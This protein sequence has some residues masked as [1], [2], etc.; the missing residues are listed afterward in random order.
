MS[1]TID[2]YLTHLSP[3]AYL[4]HQAFQDLCAKHGVTIRARPVDLG[5]VF[6]SNGGLPFAKR[7][8][9]RLD[10]RMIELQRWQQERGIPLT[11]KPAFFPVAPGLADRT[12][13]AYERS[14]G[15]MLDYS[16]SVFQ[17]VWVHDRNIADEAVIASVLESLGADAAPVLADAQ[18]AEVEEIYQ[19]NKRD[20]IAAGII[21]S[22]CYVLKGEPFWGQDRLDLLE[23]ALVSDRP[24]FRP[25]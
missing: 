19:A 6:E 16:L 15:N 5:G 3:W 10:Y 4:G 24:A 25:L 7:H 9:V 8:P 17:A 22:P 13:I 21:G 11:F 18:G 2:Y 23:R 20:A 14:G 1:R 12:G